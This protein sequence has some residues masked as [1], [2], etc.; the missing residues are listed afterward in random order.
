MTSEYVRVCCYIDVYKE[1]GG[2]AK[3]HYE[4]EKGIAQVTL[5]DGKVN[6]MEFVFFEELNE[7]LDRVVSDGAKV[8]IITGRPGYFSGGLDIKL[9]PTLPPTEL[10]RLAETFARSLLRVF[11][12]PLPTVAVCSGHAV[13]GGAM[14][15][16]A[17]DLRFVVDGPYVI[18][19]NEMLV[20]IPLPSWMLLVGRSAIPVRWQ[21]ETLLHAR[22]YS[23]ADAVEKEV[24]HGLIEDGEDPIAYAM[25]Q[26]EKLSSLNFMA[27]KTSKKR[28]REGDVRQVLE[29]LKKELPFQ[30]S[31]LT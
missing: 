3:I 12:I 14:L 6:A 16:F 27:Y 24:F 1:G 10:N 25:A 4:I 28:L 17:C 8:L 9:M 21:V 7:A 13:A 26:V 31:E 5:D 23:P 29:L 18:Q 11:S 30:E 20:G 19:M 15:C 2:M 22:A